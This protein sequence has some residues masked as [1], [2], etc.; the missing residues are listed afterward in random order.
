MYTFRLQTVLD[1]RQFIEDSLKKELAEIKNQV[2]AA[3]EKL[4]A[5]QRKEMETA[6]ALKGDQEQG[7]AS[8]QAVAYHSYLHRLARAIV[9]QTAVLIETTALETRKQDELVAAVK[10]RQ[11]LEKLKDQGRDRYNQA[12]VRKEMAFIDEI[13]VNRFIRQARNRRGD[14]E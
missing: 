14:N 4:G 2:I 1:H 12:M 9:R 8:D 10:E 6:A 11:I 7:L 13:A 5:L 3:R